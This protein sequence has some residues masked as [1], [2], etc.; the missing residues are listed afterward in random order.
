MN[1]IIFN[2]NRF[3]KLVKTET[4]IKKNTIIKLLL[5][6]IVLLLLV[7]FVSVSLVDIDTEIY[8]DIETY[9]QIFY[10]I[11]VLTPIFL[12]NSLYDS[13]KSVKYAMI[14]ASQL[15]KIIYAI[16]QTNIII[17]CAMLIVL[18]MFVITIYVINSFD[19]LAT[20]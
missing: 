8:L 5:A 2:P 1:A 3:W 20:D 12:Y 15:E 4:L 14:P 18:S 17:P 19:I 11:M 10:A 16:I 9:L 7:Y 6:L 13:I